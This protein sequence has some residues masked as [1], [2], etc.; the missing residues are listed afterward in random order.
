MTVRASVVIPNWNGARLLPTCLDSLRAQTEPSFE[1]I[2]VDNA[3]EDDSVA[4]VRRDYP[5]V[6]LIALDRNRG[7]TGGVNAGIMAAQGEVVALLNTDVEAHP[8]WLRALLAAFEVD[9]Q[10]GMVASRIMLFDRRDAFHSAGDQY[11]R[12]GIPRNRGVWEQDRGQFSQRAY[13][14]GPCGG[15][16]AYRKSLL[17]DA[18]LFDERLFMYLE[19]VDLAWRA[20]LLGY[21]CL[22][23]PQAVVYHRLSASGGGT[24]SSFFTGRNTVAVVVKDLPGPLLRRHWRC[25]VRAQG[26]VAG[27]ALRAWRGAAARARLRGLL[28]AIPFSLR[29]L[30][31]RRLVQ[32]R[33][34]VPL[35]YLESLLV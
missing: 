1:T 32:R 3:S 14:F 13:V 8:K 17:L 33:R 18:G 29:L 7:F 20:Q 16:A 35:E 34:R 6:R 25:I 5:E 4:L 26:R 9:P 22:Y 31:A 11:G 30:S 19:D 15:A 12:D 27:D 21:R 2:V 28:A 23:E 24:L 10:V